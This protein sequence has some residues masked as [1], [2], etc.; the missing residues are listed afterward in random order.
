ME[1]NIEVPNVVDVEWA[2][3]EMEST[4]KKKCN[5]DFVYY[6]QRANM[7][8]DWVDLSTLPKSKNMTNIKWVEVRNILIKCKVLSEI[9]LIELNHT[10]SSTIQVK[11]KNSKKNISTGHLL[12]LKVTDLFTSK[13]TLKDEFYLHK[14]ILNIEYNKNRSLY[15]NKPI[16]TIC[17]TCGKVK[18]YNRLCDLTRRGFSCSTCGLHKS[19]PE[20]FMMS[21]F[22]MKGIEFITEY[23]IKETGK[24][25]DFKVGDTFIEVHGKQHFIE[26]TGSWEGSYLRSLHSDKYKRLYVK[27]KGLNLIELDCRVS[28]FEGLVNVI[29]KNELLEDITN[30][31]KIK[32]RELIS[33]KLSGGLFLDIYEEYTNTH[34]TVND[35]TNKYNISK[36]TLYRGFKKIGKPLIR[37]SK[38]VKCITTG[39]I[40]NSVV[41]AIKYYNLP[42]GCKIGMVCNGKRKSAGKHPITGEPLH[43]EFVD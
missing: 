13:K 38:K 22:E 33:N 21:Y 25:F 34:I 17:D 32:M 20:I 29:N 40:H 28:D 10:A 37:S 42:T 43:W 3:E 39:S 9:E 15:D 31:E 1:N 26:T 14:N 2:K 16:D 12:E 23:C 35:I 27:N 11:Y 4:G 7:D 41:D 5:K 18:T 19:Y 6:V 30:L 8:I 36:S 24:R